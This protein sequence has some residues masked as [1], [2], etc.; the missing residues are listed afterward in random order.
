MAIARLKAVNS[1]MNY[2]ETGELFSP[3]KITAFYREKVLFNK[4][5]LNFSFS[6]RCLVDRGERS[7]LK[8][9]VI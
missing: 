6:D 1:L 9:E 7:L 2:V 8:L 5:L 4:I 3:E